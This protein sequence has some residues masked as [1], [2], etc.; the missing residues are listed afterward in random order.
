ML[1]QEYHIYFFILFTLLVFYHLLCVPGRKESSQIMVF[2][3]VKIH[4][5]I[6]YVHCGALLATPKDELA[7]GAWY[8]L[9]HLSYILL[10]KRNT[11]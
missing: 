2:K 10:H 7:L 11:I 5:F 3:T 8:S 4:M 1:L 9:V 6:V